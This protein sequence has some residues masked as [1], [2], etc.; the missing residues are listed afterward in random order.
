MS[1]GRTAIMPQVNQPEGFDC[2]GWAWP[3][4]RAGSS[5]DF[6]EN[7][8]K[9]VSWEATNKRVT[10]EFFAKH[11]VSELWQREDFGPRLQRSRFLVPAVRAR[12]RHE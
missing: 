7:G 11:S 8:A 2:P 5:S 9:A 6:C 1:D 4:P 10:P 12:L 3:D